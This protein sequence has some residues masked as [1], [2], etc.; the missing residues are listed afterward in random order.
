M[1]LLFIILIT[2]FALFAQKQ[3]CVQND[4][5]SNNYQYHVEYTCANSPDTG[6]WSDWY[7]IGEGP[8]NATCIADEDFTCEGKW[9]AKTIEVR[10][11]TSNNMVTIKLPEQY[12]SGRFFL[13]DPLNENQTGN[14]SWDFINQVLIY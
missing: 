13:I 6:I 14:I 8:K 3:F 5:P 7:Q 1:K 2:P 11:G 12:P 4:T 10:T 9:T